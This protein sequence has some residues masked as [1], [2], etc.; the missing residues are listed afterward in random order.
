MDG[1][2]IIKES[3]LFKHQSDV[4][5]ATIVFGM[6]CFLLALLRDILLWVE[7]NTVWALHGTA[8]ALM[9]PYGPLWDHM[10]TGIIR[11]HK[12]PYGSIRAHTVPI[13]SHK[14]PHGPIRSHKCPYGPISA[15]TVQ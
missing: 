13:R 12:C 4:Q 15:H 11:F 5:L 2:E 8:W 10:G 1:L 6:S 3:E 7:L 9:G 14:S